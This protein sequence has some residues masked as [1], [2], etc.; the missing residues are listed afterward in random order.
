VQAVTY[1]SYNWLYYTGR[2]YGNDAKSLRHDPLIQ[3]SVERPLLEPAQDLARAPTFSRLAHSVDRKDLYRLTRTLVDH[4]IAS[5]PEPL[6]AIVLDLD[7]SD[8]P[9]HGQQAFAF[10]KHHYQR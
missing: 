4:C 3:L 1:S 2:F 6:A 7:P 5:Y 10:Y 8:D 9:T